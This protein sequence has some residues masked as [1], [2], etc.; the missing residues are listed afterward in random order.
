MALR[1]RCSRD[2]VHRH[3]LRL[4]IAGG[5]TLALIYEASLSFALVATTP[6]AII[7]VCV[8]SAIMIP[9]VR[10]EYNITKLMAPPATESLQEQR[11][12]ELA[13]EF[14]LARTNQATNASR[15]KRLKGS[16]SARS[17]IAPPDRSKRELFAPLP[18]S[19]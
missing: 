10:Q 15:N 5:N 6:T 18:L 14:S 17:G 19:I 4:G 9:L 13:K 7:F 8:L 1:A 11:I 3:R 16:T 2:R 12:K